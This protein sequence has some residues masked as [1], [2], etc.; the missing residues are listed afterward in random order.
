MAPPA[1]MAII[2][3]LRVGKNSDGFSLIELILVLVLLGISSVIAVP[4]IERGLK[5]REARQ[6]AVTLAAVARDSSDRARTEG[7]PQ[8]LTLN[9]A[10][11]SYVG[12]SGQEVSLAANLR[13]IDVQGGET[14]E[15]DLRQFLFFPNG[16]NLGGTIRVGGD[17]AA[18]S[19][20]LHPLTGRVEVLHDERS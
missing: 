5:S 17:G 19:V 13:F 11:N 18:Y 10:S 14:T 16:S 4:A 7:Y 8:Q 6:T 3:M 12:P 15:R 1:V 2:A 20:R 9:L